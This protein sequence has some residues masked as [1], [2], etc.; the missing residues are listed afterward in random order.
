MKLRDARLVHADLLPDLLH[1]GVA[2]VVERENAALAG[3]QTAKRGTHA[4]ARLV[5]FEQPIGSDRF[6]RHEHRRK[7]GAVERLQVGQRR[8]GLDGADAH[9]RAL[10][11]RFVGADP[12]RQIGQARLGAELTAELFARRFEFATDAAD[13]ARPGVTAKRVDHRATHPSLGERLELDPARLVEP[14]RRVDQTQHAVLD[15]IAEIDRMGHR[16]GHASRQ[17]LDKRKTRL[18]SDLLMFG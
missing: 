7:R 4:V 6:T 17:R 1:R 5:L 11:L 14:V 12:A 3:R 10:E 2:E 9:D 13:A 16:R 8:G 15:E 18:H